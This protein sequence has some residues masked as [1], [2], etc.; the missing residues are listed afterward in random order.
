MAT[1]DRYRAKRADMVYSAWNIQY[2]NA[3]HPKKIIRLTIIARLVVQKVG[4]LCLVMLVLSRCTLIK[5]PGMYRLHRC[6]RGIHLETLN[7]QGSLVICHEFALLLIVLTTLGERMMGIEATVISS[8]LIGTSFTKATRRRIQL[9][10]VGISHNNVLRLQCAKR[11]C[12]NPLNLTIELSL[13]LLRNAR[14]CLSR[15]QYDLCIMII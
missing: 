12:T 4:L 6:N 9:L 5:I 11:R 15:P 7:N 2:P 13:L 8:K 14:P 3:Y 1:I 10:K